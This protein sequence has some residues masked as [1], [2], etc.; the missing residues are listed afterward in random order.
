MAMVGIG[1]KQGLDETGSAAVILVNLK[2]I[3]HKT[4]GF[5]ALEDGIVVVVP[6]QDLDKITANYEIPPKDLAGGKIVKKAVNPMRWMGAY[7]AVRGRHLIIGNTEA[8]VRSVLTAK[9]LQKELVASQRAAL[10]KTEVLLHLG[11]TAWADDWDRL[12]RDLEKEMKKKQT[13]GPE[14]VLVREFGS[15]MKH[16]KFGLVG[17]RIEKGLA[18]QVFTQFQSDPNVTKVLKQLAGNNEASTLRGLPT[19]DVISAFAINGPSSTSVPVAEALI[20]TAL[21]LF[22]S[23]KK[24]VSAAHQPALVGIFGEVWHR[25]KGSRGALYRNP[26]PSEHGPYSLVAIL[27]TGDSK[28]FL[29]EMRKLAVFVNRS[30][31]KLSSG[32]GSGIDQA[33]VVRLIRELGDNKYRVRAQA[34]VKL[35]LIGEPALP[36]LNEALKTSKDAEVLARAKKIKIRIATVGNRAVVLLGTNTDLFETAIANVEAKRDSLAAHASFG[37]FRKLRDANSK[38]ELHLSVANIEAAVS[39]KPS[40]PASKSAGLSALALSAGRQ[41]VRVDILFSMSDVATVMRKW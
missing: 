31:M 6:F 38:V 32:S 1:I 20:G 9:P 8:A 17:I 25:L 39:G 5:K 14:A 34:S 21:Q 28:K 7:F 15:V 18:F 33:T 4:A 37:R 40:D 10:S 23:T 13:D 41:Y 29:S 11:T 26:K 2:A 12:L 35:N 19:G 3:G 30:G 36:Y 27:D 24:F 16:L 22:V